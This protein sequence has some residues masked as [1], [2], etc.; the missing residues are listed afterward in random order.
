LKNKLADFNKELAKVRKEHKRLPVWA[1]KVV[2]EDHV[3]L[4]KK[5]RD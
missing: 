1:A 3:K 4:P 5:K 2:A